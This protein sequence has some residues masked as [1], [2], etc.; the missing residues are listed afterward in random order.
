M[1]P[2]FRPVLRNT[3]YAIRDDLDTASTESQSKDVEGALLF[4]TKCTR[5]HELRSPSNRALS[6]EEWASTITRMAGKENSDISPSDRDRIIAFVQAEAIRAGE[7][8]AQQIKLA[9]QIDLPGAVSGRIS[10]PGE[11]DYY[12]FTVPE[13][14]TLGPWWVIQPFDNPNETG[15]DTVYP[16]ETEIDLEKEYTGKGGRKIGWYQSNGTGNNAFS[17]VPEDDVVGY[18][19]TYID[20]D[21]EQTEILSLGSDDGIKVWVNDQLIWSRHVHRAIA[22]AQDVIALPLARGRNKLLVKIENGYGPWG[23]FATIGGYSIDLFAETFN[24]P[25]VPSLTLL[26]AKGEV[27]ANNAGVNGGRDARI[28]Y[29]FSRPGDYALR[30]ED[31]TGKGGA[32]YIYRLNVAPASPDFAM[33]VTPDNPNIGQGGTVL[34][35]VIATRRVGFTGEIALEVANLPPGVTA[36]SGA[37][38]TDMNQGFITLTAAPDAPLEYRVAQV[39]GSVKTV[40][41]EVIQRPATPVE[42]YRIQNQPQPVQRSSLVVSVTEV[43]SVTLAVSPERVTITPGK[44]VPLKV[45]ANRKP[46]SRQE[47][48]LTVVGLPSGVRPQG[49]VT[50]L[51]GNQT[52]A[53]LVLEPNIVG[54]GVTVRTNPFIGRELAIRPYNIVINASVGQTI[55]ASSPA[56]QLSIGN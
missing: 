48:T 21:K 49:Q 5:C 13:G 12:T 31:V 24:S 34:L 50:I 44:P 27:L 43:P 55:V 1:G 29:S 14:K 46:G 18:A 39:I 2:T 51:K 40:S 54:A 41:G 52:E 9:Q 28:D 7:Q 17:N 56:M 37:I 23:F 3:Q 35:T 19:L 53:T 20:S 32:G 22:P 38:P 30:V 6:A 8:M 36:S 11:V 45:V 16:P 47:L 4:Q 25:L 42:V 10:Q 26:N 15:F 33:S